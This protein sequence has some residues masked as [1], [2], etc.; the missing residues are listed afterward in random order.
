[1][2]YLIILLR[3][4]IICL[5]LENRLLVACCVLTTKENYLEN[6]CWRLGELTTDVKRISV[7]GYVKWVKF[8][9]SVR[10]M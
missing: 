9:I 10:E 5:S 2:P 6:S 8:R 7:A 1:M 3:G 4:H